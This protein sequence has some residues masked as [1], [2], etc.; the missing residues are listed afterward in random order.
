MPPIALGTMTA[1][2]LHTTMAPTTPVATSTMDGPA[3]FLST[4]TSDGG[5]PYSLPPRPP[6]AA[7]ATDDAGLPRRMLKT[8]IIYYCL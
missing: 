7:T 3:D 2:A 6:A 8:V 1:A 5:A 4:T